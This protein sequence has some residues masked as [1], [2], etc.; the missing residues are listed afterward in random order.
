LLEKLKGP[1]V[2]N[3]NASQLRLVLHTRVVFHRHALLTISRA[4]V[5]SV[6]EVAKIVV[7]VV[8][9]AVALALAVAVAA[10]VAVS[11][12]AAPV[13]VAVAVV[14]AAFPPSEC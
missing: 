13:P 4:V 9:V 3:I 14:A 5:R 8:A 12:A 6:M 1:G 10:Y 2:V 11:V 7:V